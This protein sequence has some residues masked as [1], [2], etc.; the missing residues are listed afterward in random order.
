MKLPHSQFAQ[1]SRE[2]TVG[3]LLSSTHQYGSGKHDFFVRFSFR[4]EA[5]EQL[6]DALIQH[7]SDNP[8]T[9]QEQTTFGIRYV[10]E[11]PLRCPDGRYPLVRVVWFID[12]EDNVPR[13]VTAYPLRT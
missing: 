9:S 10:I 5:W 8:V 6:A 11:G 1:V 12:F 4:P 2:K 13:M 7:A 3:Y